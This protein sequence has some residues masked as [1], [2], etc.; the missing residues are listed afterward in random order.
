MQERNSLRRLQPRDGFF[1]FEGLSDHL[2]NTVLDAVFTPGLQRSLPKSSNESLNTGEANAKDLAAL[3]IEHNN[4]SL[5]EN[6]LH[7]LYLARL[8]VMI[9]QNGQD[10]DLQATR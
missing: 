5:T 4:P 9:T 2:L 6:A 7:L 3:P 8:K 1:Q 10:R